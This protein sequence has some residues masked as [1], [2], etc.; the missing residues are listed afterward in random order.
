MVRGIATD[1]KKNKRINRNDE[2]YLCEDLYAIRETVE[3]YIDEIRPEDEEVITEYKH[4]KGMDFVRILSILFLGIFGSISLIS[5]IYLI[6]IQTYFTGFSFL[7]FGAV[8]ILCFIL[9][10]KYR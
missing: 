6:F 10:E 3:H 1:G 2:K 5:G 4:K 8:A 9:Y 7:I